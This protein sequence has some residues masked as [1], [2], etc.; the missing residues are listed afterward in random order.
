MEASYYKRLEG[1]QVRC[2]LCP[3]H[4]VIKPGDSGICKVRSNRDG[5]LHADVYG[6]LSAANFDPVEKKPLYHF[7]PGYEILSLG[8]L[9]CNFNCSCCQNYSIS[10][11][12]ESDFP[13]MMKLNES[14]ILTLA[15]RTPENIGIAFTYNEPGVWFEYML[16]I[17]RAAKLNGL[18]TAMVSNGYL[19]DPPLREL[20]SCIDAFN[21]DLK[22]FNDSVHQEFT[23]AKLKHV[24]NSLNKISA[25]GNH[26]EITSL[27]VPGVGDDEKEF[28]KMIRWIAKELGS[29][30]PLHIS[31]YFPK[32]K[33]QTEATSPALIKRFIEIASAELSYVYAG[34]LSDNDYQ[35]TYCPQCNSLAISR[36]GYRTEIN[37]LNS[38][39]GCR[40]CAYL[41]VKV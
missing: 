29:D 37:G 13:R 23:G 35:N 19:N 18:A 15:K 40:S 17:A 9:G 14:E 12:G 36:S 3:H 8:S 38:E 7:H 4:C 10:Q 27:I 34:N 25:N 11:S 6:A 41:I 26:L 33:L 20:L 5:I 2:L 28:E 31:R 24:K 1:K 32:Y 21:I 16:D 22:T 39:G 30:V